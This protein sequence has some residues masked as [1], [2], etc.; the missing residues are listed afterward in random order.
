MMCST[1][2]VEEFGFQNIVEYEMHM[3]K[4]IFSQKNRKKHG[5]LEGYTHS[6]QYFYY[7]I[8]RDK[9]TKKAFSNA[10]NIRFLH[11]AT[12]REINFK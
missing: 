3:P 11:F 10:R 9:V 1:V 2:A 6:T 5:K 12:K 7:K 4:Q 8:K